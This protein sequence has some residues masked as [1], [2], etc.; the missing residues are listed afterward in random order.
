MLTSTNK[1]KSMK[2]VNLLKSVLILTLILIF[3]YDFSF[4]FGPTILSCYFLTL[5]PL[6]LLFIL[7]A[8]E[9]FINNIAFLY[10]K[11]PAKY[12]VWTIAGFLITSLIAIISGKYSVSNAI[13][14]I[15]R[16]LFFI[17]PLT[18][19]FPIY[20][21]PRYLSYKLLIKF[22]VIVTYVILFLGI[23]DLIGIF[24]DIEHIRTVLGSLGNFKLLGAIRSNI[25]DPMHVLTSFEVI[26]GFP[27]IQSVFHEPGAY[28]KFILI[29][30]PI[31]YKFST[32]SYKIFSNPYLNLLAKRTFILFAW[33]GLLFAQSPIYFIFAVMF[34][35]MYFYKSLISS[36]KKNIHTYSMLF[37]L[38]GV[39][40]SLILIN[41]NFSQ[42]FLMRVWRVY[43][44]LGSFDKFIFYEPSLA[45]RIISFINCIDVFL[46]NPI[47]GVGFSNQ[48]YVMYEQL[49]A[50]PVP[51]TDE[52][53]R[54]MYADS[55]ITRVSFSTFY[56]LLAGSGIVGTSIYYYFVYKNIKILNKI[57]TYY[58]G[59][60]KDFLYALENSLYIIIFL[61]FYSFNFLNGLSWFFFGLITS[62]VLG[63][64]KNKNDIK[65]EDRDVS[66]Q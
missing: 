42:T 18:Y 61:G 47:V 5:I 44:S 66:K 2:T 58:I 60:E 46:K 6:Y 8:P 63:Y 32:T 38:F 1:V 4:I 16:E 7:K 20:F 57:K 37:L 30:L 39:I 31:I 17:I 24:F 11:T 27:R 9:K 53:M 65:I 29:M 34:T 13:Y 14:R 50:S 45:T 25:K 3:F 59:I 15:P 49:L 62:F 21:I 40:T 26:S 43:E 54:G 19:F 41:I 10:K 55:D 51:L 12:F 48:V 56:Y 64:L 28:S 36:I 35:A 22:S 33:A 52:L 23:V